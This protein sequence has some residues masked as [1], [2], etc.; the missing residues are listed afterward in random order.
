MRIEK[1]E[2][3]NL[4]S[5]Y[6]KHSI[7][8]TAN[9][10]RNSN[11]F[12][13]CGD[14]GS[15]KTTVLDA[16]TLALYGQTSRLKN[17][18]A[19]VNEIMSKGTRQ[20]SS[21]VT[22]S[23]DGKL[24]R[25]KWSQQYNRNGNL[26]P[27]ECQ[28]CEH[29][30]GIVLANQKRAFESRIESL[31]NLKYPQFSKA[32]LL[33]QG[34]FTEFLNASSGE[35]AA[36]L[37]KL[38]NT[39]IYSTLSLEAHE[40]SKAAQT[41]Y[42][43]IAR[44]LSGIQMMSEDEITKLRSEKTAIH[45]EVDGL[46]TDIDRLTK[47][48]HWLGS[49]N[50]ALKRVQEIEHQKQINAQALT[51]FESNRCILEAAKRAA[52][53]AHLFVSF[54]KAQKMHEEA[55]VALE[56]V[57]TQIPGAEQLMNLMSTSVEQYKKLQ[58]D[59][60][61]NLTDAR[62]LF[63]KVRR[64]QTELNT[65][66]G[67]HN[68][69]QIKQT[70][71]SNLKTNLLLKL[72]K[73]KEDETTLQRR[74]A[75]GEA[76][77]KENAVVESLIT[78]LGI[79]QELAHIVCQSESDMKIAEQNKQQYQDELED[80]QKAVERAQKALEAQ[81]KF[82]KEA[83]ENTL[84]ASK[85]YIDTC[86]GHTIESLEAL[87]NNLNDE[88][89]KA[90][91][92]LSYEDRRKMLREGEA[93]PLCGAI[94][95][96]YCEKIPYQVSDIEMQIKITRS[97]IDRIHK[98]GKLLEDMQK[99][100]NNAELEV[101]RYT[102]SMDAAKSQ[103]DAR[104]KHIA[105]HQLAL[106]KAHETLSNHMS[107]FNQLVAK[108]TKSISEAR[109]AQDVCK[110]LETRLENWN[111][112]I[113]LK[114]EL[115]TKKEYIQRD[116]VRFQTE[117]DAMLRELNELTSTLQR[118]AAEIDSK[119]AEI[120]SIFGD[121]N[122]DDEEKTLI[123][124]ERIADNEYAKAIEKYHQAQNALNHL[125]TTA[126]LKTANVLSFARDVESCRNAWVDGLE[127]Q[128]FADEAAFMDARLSEQDLNLLIKEAEALDEAAK[129]IASRANEA[130]KTLKD[131]QSLSLTE[132]SSENLNA[133][134]E[135]KTHLMGEKQTRLGDIMRTLQNH[136]ENLAKSTKIMADMQKAEKERARWKA[137]DDLIGNSQNTK[138]NKFRDFAQGF[139]FKI[140]LQNANYYLRDKGLMQRYELITPKNENEGEMLEFFVHDYQTG[141]TRKSSNL[142]GGEKFCMSLAL[143]LGL[144]QMAS[145]NVV[146]D[147]LFI[148]EG[149][150][151]LDDQTLDAALNMLKTLGNMNHNQLIG[152]IT[153]VS[154]VK[155]T[156]ST[157]IIAE[158]IGNGRSRLR[159]PGCA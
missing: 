150:G 96:P 153:H 90:E 94:S 65:I 59:A 83:Q 29:E 159:G 157:S 10:F 58:E 66:Q 110:C 98:A 116:I 15:G 138:K 46:K 8:F 86:N 80:A 121:K 16:I 22:F 76:Y 43:K 1:I 120:E 40:R 56:N 97:W 28:L 55:V 24:Y 109:Q 95:H 78:E 93:C 13:L 92:V 156:V 139:T 72:Q 75:Q 41:E 49:L 79:M 61:Q 114:K 134:K 7:D 91:A 129:D 128:G 112:A 6:G 107:K 155:E 25:A 106:N 152:I 135:L 53:I 145:K 37:E 20:C 14:M 57:N 88:K 31:L 4:N 44:D 74:L 131:I 82:Y 21:E 68:E 132:E 30:T 38:T 101:S 39:E 158:K 12:L 67:Q 70:D 27:P 3:E 111:K 64:L 108:Y 36:I 35:R 124:L 113:E 26:N 125:K 48:I 60:K 42:D 100:E 118:T 140:L 17:I 5:L 105:D 69:Y 34:K 99:K 104:L 85:D 137:L 133:E 141:Q 73:A 9:E 62:P 18:S 136:D 84:R 71:K 154:R 19:S 52:V 144:A 127:T 33:E 103:H 119:K 117:H 89:Q 2:I 151:T 45:V 23:V 123:N 147:S 146:I 143:A 148:D 130:D 81:Q 77:F 142:S 11:L 126:E 50:D 102:M 122:V 63:D 149:F 32:V 47:A 115:E 51:A 54:E 87:L